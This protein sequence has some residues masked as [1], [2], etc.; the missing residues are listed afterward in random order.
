MDGDVDGKDLA[1]FAE[2]FQIYFDLP[3]PE[4]TCD[5]DGNGYMELEWDFVFFTEDFGRTDCY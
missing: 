5:M 1:I 2:E 3:C 4:C